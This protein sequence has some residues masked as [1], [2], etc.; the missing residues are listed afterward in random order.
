MASQHTNRADLGMGYHHLPGLFA[1]FV[2]TPELGSPQKSGSK[3]HP[4]PGFHRPRSRHHHQFMALLTPAF[5]VHF[6]TCWYVVQSFVHVFKGKGQASCF[7]WTEKQIG[8]HQ[9]ALAFF[10]ICPSKFC[11]WSNRTQPFQKCKGP[12]SPSSS[13][14]KM[15]KISGW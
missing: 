8:T 13:F 12:A 9:Q 3:N 4:T 5:L 7:Q 14:R 11:N 6:G 15:A 1:E 2:V 10:G